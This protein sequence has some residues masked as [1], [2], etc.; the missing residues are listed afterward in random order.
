MSSSDCDDALVGVRG[1]VWKVYAE[2]DDLTVQEATYIGCFVDDSARDLGA[3]EGAW[4]NAATN[5]FELCRAHCSGHAYMSLQWGGEC[6][7][8]DAYATAGQYMQVADSECMTRTTQ[9]PCFS[10]S[11]S[12][13]GAWRQA[14]YR[15]TNVAPTH[16]VTVVS[17]PS[18]AWS[19][20]DEATRGPITKCMQR[21]AT[22][23]ADGTGNLFTSC[24]NAD[25]TGMDRDCNAAATTHA[26]VND[27]T[28]QCISQ[29]GRL[30]TS[31]EAIAEV[32]VSKGCNVDGPSD[33]SGADM[34]RL[35]TSTTCDA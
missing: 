26:D 18:W 7:C 29:G 12:C 31:E 10:S 13:G 25:G 34:N 14:I 4:T 16:Y 17:W 30:C 9:E 2:F 1:N 28:A 24:C 5:T 23:D 8:A 32:T 20:W 6:F 22:T 11:H 19:D 21:D 35:W 33:A 27:A 3:M 15:L